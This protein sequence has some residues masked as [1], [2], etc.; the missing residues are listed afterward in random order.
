[1]KGKNTLTFNQATMCEIV[2]LWLDDQFPESGK[3]SR[4]RERPETDNASVKVFDVDVAKEE[5]D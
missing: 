1:M 4:V 5:E 2:Q 3:V